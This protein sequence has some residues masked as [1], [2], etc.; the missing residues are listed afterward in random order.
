MPSAP[1][2]MT[3][4]DARLQN[5]SFLSLK[6]FVIGAGGVVGGAT[7]VALHVR[8]LAFTLACAVGTITPTRTSAHKTTATRRCPRPNTGI[9]VARRS[10]GVS[11]SVPAAAEGRRC[12]LQV[13]PPDEDV[14]G[15]E[16]RDRED[17]DLGPGQRLGERGQDPYEIEVERTVDLE[18]TPVV[19]A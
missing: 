8:S 18:D 5:M 16:G 14:V 12:A 19:L 17:A 1:M 13:S 11:H 7:G 6:F 9:N 4:L 3:A 15:L 2:R 10:N